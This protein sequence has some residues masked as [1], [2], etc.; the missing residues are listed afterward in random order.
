[1]GY[2]PSADASAQATFLTEYSARTGQ[3]REIFQRVFNAVGDGGTGE[4]V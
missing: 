2:V 1:M 4:E 3:V